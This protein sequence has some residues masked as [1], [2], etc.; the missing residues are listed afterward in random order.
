M[1]ITLGG[2]D[3]NTGKYLFSIESKVCPLPYSQIAMRVR[4]LI[5]AVTEITNSK[6]DLIEFD[7]DENV[8]VMMM[9]EKLILIRGGL[10]LMHL[11]L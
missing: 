8:I 4:F 11:L 7:K 1:D 6:N 10:I 3:L 2:V 9:E 5:A